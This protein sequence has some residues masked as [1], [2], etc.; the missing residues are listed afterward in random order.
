MFDI[1][2][3]S[4]KL[5]KLELPSVELQVLQRE[6]GTAGHGQNS[7]YDQQQLHPDRKQSRNEILCDLQETTQVESEL[8]HFSFASQRFL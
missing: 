4:E 5:T 1:R 3:Q 6:A 8:F 2:P 7:S